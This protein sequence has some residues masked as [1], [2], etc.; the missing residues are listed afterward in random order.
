MA[1]DTM[2]I[3]VTCATHDL[4]A[5]QAR[6]RGVSLPAMLGEIA[7]ER[8]RNAIWRSERE[9]SRIDSQNPNAQTELQEWEATLEDSLG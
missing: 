9:A 5:Q 8:R 3:R 6:E 4:L 2:T 1:A 7:D